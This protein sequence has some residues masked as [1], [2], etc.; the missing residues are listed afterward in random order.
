MDTE[1]LRELAESAQKRAG[2]YHGYFEAANEA[3]IDHVY[4]GQVNLALEMRR[5]AA[6]FLNDYF[7]WIGHANAYKG[8]IAMVELQTIVED[9]ID[10]TPQCP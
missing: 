4:G 2:D 3:A 5:K 10:A 1:K 6:G 7:Y 8:V 9:E